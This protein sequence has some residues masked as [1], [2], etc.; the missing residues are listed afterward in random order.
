MFH[1]IHALVL[2]RACR[3]AAEG[4]REA[5]FSTLAAHAKKLAFWA[6]N[7][8]VNF[9]AKHALVAAEIAEITGIP[10]NYLSKILHQLARQ[11]LFLSF[12]RK[13][14]E[15]QW[16]ELGRMSNGN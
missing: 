15:N 12:V 2:A 7:C 14:V 6:E 16:I 9:A 8:P 1:F 4:D 5:I 3:E 13:A 11:G 10:K